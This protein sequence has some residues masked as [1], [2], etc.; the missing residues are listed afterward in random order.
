MDGTN[1]T[2]KENETSPGCGRHYTIII[3][4]VSMGANEFAQMKKAL[5]ITINNM[6]TMINQFK[7]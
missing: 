3:A 7:I 2:F 1:E 5:S 6:K 4:V